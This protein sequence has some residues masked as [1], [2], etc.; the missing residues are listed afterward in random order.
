MT[1]GHD[2]SPN[3][4]EGDEITPETIALAVKR[5]REAEDAMYAAI[6]DA[7]RQLLDVKIEVGKGST[8][9]V[10]LQYPVARVTSTRC[11]K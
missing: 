11:Y 8:C 5:V 3:R 4:I 1:D 6:A 7:A 10:P 2:A 9:G